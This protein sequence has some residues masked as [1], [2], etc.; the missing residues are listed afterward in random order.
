VKYNLDGNGSN[1]TITGNTIFNTSD[2]G[3]TLYLYA[4]NILGE[5]TQSVI[6]TVNL[7]KFKVIYNNFSGLLKGL[8]TAFNQSSH[9]DLQNLSSIILERINAGKIEFNEVINVTDDANVSDNE[10]DLDTNIN[11]SFNRT[12][13]N[14]TALPNFNK[15]ATLYLY[16]LSF[17]DPRILRDGSICSPTICTEISYTGGALKTLKFNVT[18]FS[19]YS[20]EET[21]TDGGEGAAPPGEGGTGVVYECSNNSECSDD[22]VCLNN[23]CAKL[24]DIK[25]IEFES[26]IKLGEFFDF[27]YY[28]KGLA[29]IN[30]D[31]EINFWI[32]KGGE[33]VTSGS[34]VIYLGSFEEKT[35]T[36]KIFL[37][38]TIESGIYKFY[39]QVV[40]P[41]YSA[42]SHRTIEVEV[43][44]GIV[45]IISADNLKTYIILGLII[46]A[47]LILSIIVYL[48][49]KKIKKSIA[50][51]FA[52]ETRWFK[53]YK[54]SV[55]VSALIVILGVLAY[56]LN[57]FEFL[58]G[59]IRS[60]SFN[61]FLKT[62][63]VLFGLLVI[64]FV[65]NKT[66]FFQR[67]KAWRAERRAINRLRRAKRREIER[68]RKEKIRDEAKKVIKVRPKIK[69]SIEGPRRKGKFMKALIKIL[70]FP[71]KFIEEIVIALSRFSGK[72]LRGLRIFLKEKRR[73][74][75][76]RKPKKV[77]KV[78]PKTKPSIE[79]PRRKRKFM[80][81]FIKVISFPLK[82]IEEI[83]IGLAKFSGKAVRGLGI[84][85]KTIRRKTTL[86]FRELKV[87]ETTIPKF[88]LYAL[89]KSE[90][91]RKIVKK[92]GKPKPKK[93]KT[94]L[95]ILF[96]LKRTLRGFY[97][98]SKEIDR[99]LLRM[100][101]KTPERFEI[102]KLGMDKKISKFWEIGKKSPAYL[103]PKQTQ[104]E[105]RRLGKLEKSYGKI[106]LNIVKII[107]NSITNSLRYMIDL[108]RP[109]GSSIAKKEKDLAKEGGKTIK[110]IHKDVFYLLKKISGRKSHEKMVHDFENKL[111]KTGKFTKSHLETLRKVVNVQLEFKK[112]KS[113]LHHDVALIEKKSKGLIKDLKGYL[114]SLDKKEK[115]EVRKIVRLS[116]RRS[117]HVMGTIKYDLRNTLII[118]H[119]YLIKLNVLYL[120]ARYNIKMKLLKRRRE[121]IQDAKELESKKLMEAKEEEAEK[122]EKILEKKRERRRER[123]LAKEVFEEKV[124][125]PEQVQKQ[126]KIQKPLEKMIKPVQRYIERIRRIPLLERL[127]RETKQELPQKPK[128]I[129][130]IEKPKI[131]REKP[132]ET[133]KSPIKKIEK[134][135]YLVIKPSK[136][137][138]VKIIPKKPKPEIYKV[139][140]KKTE[141]KEDLNIIQDIVEKEKRGEMRKKTEKI[142]K[143]QIPPEQ[144]PAEIKKMVKP[145]DKK[146]IK[147]EN[148]EDKIK[149]K[150]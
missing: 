136:K 71:F 98:W 28:V 2:G 135:K 78:R 25:I 90:K 69:P 100:L 141:T 45:T 42:E 40:H 44:G 79:R 108:I 102:P 76:R 89:F 75:R 60:P 52:Q 123:V 80:R 105:M 17:S 86:L 6:F 150:G 132:I 146:I 64:I 93:R 104:K 119:N 72:A 70:T 41:S 63:L 31:V 114:Y 22:E 5:T 13:I 57:L 97:E 94:K 107:R 48:E 83:A 27:I 117:T 147:D 145:K 65:L 68:L 116:K 4:N 95:R 56:S 143:P 8:S 36:T 77:I 129:Q 134:E 46:L 148:L 14:S 127:E 74:R 59:W 142:E 26:P 128:Q 106:E 139:P 10:V 110:E 138:E 131:I 54:I 112:T 130:K 11:I 51:G 50:W 133:P 120:R 99:A 43:K 33:I 144:R 84:S 101:K 49:R 21:P 61:Y 115:Q 16:N 47:L 92:V 23:K 3:H 19:V 9:E 88:N 113:I 34:D 15:S 85:L 24:F 73:E 39:V 55:L 91:K 66:N 12:E 29:D 149:K 87:P 30:A 81:A 82:F 124:E 126:I 35:E 140:R 18:Q 137:P 37:P 53:R 20:A 122:V 58:A 103:I 121:I 32:E 109:L 96:K 111:V 67:F 38:S 1:T 7:T 62:I 125:K 118:L